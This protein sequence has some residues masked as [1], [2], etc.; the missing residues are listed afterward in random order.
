MSSKHTDSIERLLA[1][2]G[3]MPAA[4]IAL[5]LGLSQPTISR[6]LNASP[7][8]LRIGQT[9]RARYA[10]PRPIQAGDSNWKLYQIASDGQA[11]IA[12][13][14]HALHQ[15]EFFLEPN[16][17][18]D[19]YGYLLNGEDHPQLFPD[20]PW[21]LEDMRPQGYLSRLL[22]RTHGPSL[23]IGTNPENWTIEEAIKAILSYGDDTPGNFI[24][25]GQ[26]IDTFLASQEQSPVIEALDRSG[27]YN[28]IAHHVTEDGELPNSSAGGEQPKFTTCISQAD[29]AFQHVIVKFSG[30]LKTDAGRRWADLLSAEAIASEE[31]TRIGLN[32][33]PSRLIKT[34][35]RAYLEVDRFDRSGRIGRI[36]T[37]SLRSLIAGLSGELEQNW[38]HSC[39]SLVR[40]KWLKQADADKAA[41][42]QHFGQLIGNSDMHL[43]NLSLFLTP[44]LPLRLCPIY[45]MLPMRYA[46]QRSGDLPT[47]PLEIRPPRPEE[48]PHWH[49]AAQAAKRFW[50]RLS[51][52]VPISSEFREIAQS[53]LERIRN[54]LER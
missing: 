23:G 26:A 17:E 24:L 11:D 30:S 42:Y 43:G 40:Q 27:Q 35:Q 54:E 29:G 12:G 37:L 16:W 19:K 41:I 44:E 47:T 1:T 39:Q 48:R 4:D 25:G 3:S 18:N 6:A 28:R 49:P 50:N 46:P 8:I 20:L 36:G 14:L 51:K 7:K 15:G 5:Q 53:N 13:T 32:A 38:S 21:F 2:R 22:A 34:E 33:A 52:D 9:R 10:L 31:L 45:D